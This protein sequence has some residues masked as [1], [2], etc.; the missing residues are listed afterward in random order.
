M[1][2]YVWI[3]ILG[4]I[5]LVSTGV[6]LG[7]I[8]KSSMLIKKLRIPKRHLILNFMLLVATLVDISLIIY[9]FVLVKNQISALT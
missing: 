6:F 7:T 2:D 8:S 4:G 9:V 5:A 3:F 1:R